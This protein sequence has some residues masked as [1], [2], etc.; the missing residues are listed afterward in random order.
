LK[1]EPKHSFNQVP[2]FVSHTLTS[3][4]A[5]EKAQLEDGFKHSEKIRLDLLKTY[6]HGPW[7]PD[8]HAYNMASLGHE[9]FEGYELQVLDD[10]DRYSRLAKNI[11]RDAGAENKRKAEIRQVKVLEINKALIEKINNSDS[12]NAH[13]VATMIHEQ[14]TSMSSVQRLATEDKNMPCRGDGGMPASVRT[15]T[16]WLEQHLSTFDKPRRKKNLRA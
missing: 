12:Y 16:R 1:D 2:L 13:R 6:K 14:W 15:I 8:E 11:R 9:S 3:D 10:D 7:T 5:G 4:T